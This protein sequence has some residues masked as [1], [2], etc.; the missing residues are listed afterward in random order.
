LGRPGSSWKSLSAAE[1]AGFQLN[2]SSADA[3]FLVL[4]HQMESNKEKSSMTDA[5]GSLLQDIHTMDNARLRA[6][7][8]VDPKLQDHAHYIKD[9]IDRNVG[10]ILEQYR[11]YGNGHG[12]EVYVAAEKF[13]TQ[14]LGFAD[15]EGRKMLRTWIA[16]EMPPVSSYYMFTIPRAQREQALA[17]RFEQ[18]IDGKVMVGRGKAPTMNRERLDPGRHDFT[19]SLDQ[20]TLKMAVCSQ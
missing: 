9:E 8:A 13:I 7:W 1:S 19:F 4:N 5:S 15:T 12:E 20:T 16:K 6:K 17:T 14:D 3:D 18:L 2:N 11:L 10:E